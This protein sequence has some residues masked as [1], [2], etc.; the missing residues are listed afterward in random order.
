MDRVFELDF[1]NEKNCLLEVDKVDLGGKAKILA[2]Q[3]GMSD[4]ALREIKKSCR[5]YY[6]ELCT[7]IKARVDFNDP[8]LNAV[9]II[10]PSSLGE[11]L[12]PLIQMFPNLIVNFKAEDLEDEWS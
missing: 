4:S 8:I 3:K 7:Q 6:I 5:A 11:S 9:Q 1:V 2:L 12:I 10:H